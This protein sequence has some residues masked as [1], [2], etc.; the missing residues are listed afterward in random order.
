M[1][2]MHGAAC[3]GVTA[4]RPGHRVAPHVLATRRLLSGAIALVASVGAA[5][6]ADIT[7][8]TNAA[9]VDRIVATY[10]CEKADKITVTY[11]NAGDDSLAVVPVEGGDRIFVAVLSGS[12]ARY[13]AGPYVW[14]TKGRDASLYDVRAGDDAPAIDTC[15]EVPG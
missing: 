6:A 14:W 13:A 8:P 11:I 4:R 5:A 3:A 2:Q 1:R 15:A 9:S 10:A 7:L 12:G